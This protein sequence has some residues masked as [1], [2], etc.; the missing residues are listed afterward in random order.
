MMQ[1]LCIALALL[2]ACPAMGQMVFVSA[3]K[4]AAASGYAANQFVTTWALTA[5]N[6]AGRTITLPL[7]AGST[8]D[9]VVDWGDGAS[10]TITNATDPDAAHEYAAIGTKTVILTGTVGGFGF[11]NGGDKAKFRTVEFWG[12]SVGFTGSGLANAFYGCSSAT[13]FG[14]SIPYY[15]VTSLASAFR[16]CT[17]V[18]SL[19]NLSALTNVIT[20]SAMATSA[21]GL[22][23]VPVLMSTP[24]LVTTTRAFNGV[25][26]GMSGTVV[27]LWTAGTVTSYANTFTGCTGLSNYGD[28]PNAWKGL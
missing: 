13:S 9:C 14:T 3:K 15:P 16:S 26:A 8:F 25:G 28:I 10:G 23:T 6:A 17:S 4:P 2:A 24:N 11:N 22:T 1:R 20:I 27:D 12:P 21:T 5:T 19:P 18:T 7:R